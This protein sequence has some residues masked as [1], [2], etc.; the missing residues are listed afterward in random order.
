MVLPGTSLS[1]A[2]PTDFRSKAPGDTGRSITYES[3]RSCTHDPQ[4]LA[5]RITPSTW[6]SVG[7]KLWF[8]ILVDQS[9][10]SV[11]TIQGQLTKRNGVREQIIIYM[12]VLLTN[13]QRPQKLTFNMKARSQSNSLYLRILVVVSDGSYKLR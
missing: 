5:I 4:P 10:M 9:I 1:L 12:W 13:H 2:N 3:M 11:W 6:L 8:Q 7:H